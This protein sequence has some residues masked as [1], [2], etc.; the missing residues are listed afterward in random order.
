MRPGDPL[1]T[2]PAQAAA[3]E[4]AP[5]AIDVDA[6]RPAIDAPSEMAAEADALELPFEIARRTGVVFV[7]GI[8]TQTANETFLDWAE[9]IVELLTDWRAAKAEA[10]ATAAALDAAA[11][12]DASAARPSP[13]DRI[14]DPVWTAGFA[15]GGTTAPS[16]ELIVPAHAG[17]PETTWVLTEAWWAAALRPPSL[18]RTIDYLAKRIARVVSGIGAGYRKRRPCPARPGRA[19][20]PHRGRP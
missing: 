8:G 6:P 17:L 15:I 18:G 12:P 13:T 4:G 16:L 20:E 9:P 19:G 5:P 2:G 1:P 7:H 10:E 11:N 14:D 3:A